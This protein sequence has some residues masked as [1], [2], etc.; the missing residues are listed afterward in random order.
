MSGESIE[1]VP[2]DE[3]RARV[4]VRSLPVPE[5]RPEFRARLRAGFV[6]GAIAP[7]AGRAQPWSFA[8]RPH[9]ALRWA[10]LPVAAAALLLAVSALNQGPRWELIE[11]RGEGIVVVGGVPVP[12]QHAADL[13]RR[14]KGGARV[15]VPEGG[16]LELAARGTIVMQISAGTDVTLPATPGR[17]FGRRI[18]ASVEHG[19]MRITTGRRFPGARLVVSTPEASVEVTGTTLAVICEPSGTCVCVLEGRVAVAGNGEGAPV[20]VRE[21]R[22]RY[23]F[24]DARSPESAEMRPVEH[25]ML[26]ALRDR[27]RA[28]LERDRR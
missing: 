19:E 13:A 14:L 17:W 8:A 11:S 6:S 10:A 4:A 26:S 2:P 7:A 18:E 16:E 27:R 12:A 24:N 5:A 15:R 28:I 3:A 22:R 9:P 21:G 25:A 20:T 1:R 23:V